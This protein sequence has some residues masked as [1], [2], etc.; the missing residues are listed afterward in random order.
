MMIHFK[1]RI[2]KENPLWS[3]E[4][5]HNQLTHLG[6]IDV[7]TP[8]TIAKYLSSIRKPPSK[9]VVANMEDLSDKPPQRHQGNGFLYCSYRF[10]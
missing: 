3:P 6:I 8:S 5:I 2:Y 7:P 9:K 4:R 1:K 10:L